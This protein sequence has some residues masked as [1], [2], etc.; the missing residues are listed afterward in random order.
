MSLRVLARV[1]VAAAVAILSHRVRRQ[2]FAASGGRVWGVLSVIKRNACLREIGG[3]AAVAILPP[4]CVA[5]AS[6]QARERM[7][8]AGGTPGDG[9]DPQLLVHLQ[10]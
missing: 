8:R 7:G 2:G 10:Y 9:A 1:V 6:H 5:V 4:E 3:V